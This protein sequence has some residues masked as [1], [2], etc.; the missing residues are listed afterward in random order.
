MLV[1]DVLPTQT[2][3]MTVW[4]FKKYSKKQDSGFMGGLDVNL[5]FLAKLEPRK[6]ACMSI[7]V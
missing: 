3:Q 6:T 4:N 7:T 1:R 5:A 2:L